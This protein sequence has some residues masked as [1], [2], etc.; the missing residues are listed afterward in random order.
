MQ[1]MVAVV[2]TW[3]TVVDMQCVVVVLVTRGWPAPPTTG[4]TGSSP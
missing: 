1:E 4:P 2:G 3:V